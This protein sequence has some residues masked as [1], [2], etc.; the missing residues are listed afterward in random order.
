M[1]IFVNVK[2]SFIKEAYEKNCKIFKYLIEIN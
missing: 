2:C 1:I